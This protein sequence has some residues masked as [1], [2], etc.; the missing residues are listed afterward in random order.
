MLASVHTRLATGL[1]RRAG[2]RVFRFFRRALDP[3][4]TATVPA[5]LE[6]R[7]LSEA[8]VGPLCRRPELDL[9]P[10]KV[11]DA[12]ERGDLCAGAYAAGELVGY[13]WFAFAPVPHLDSVWVDFHQQGVWMYKSLVLPSQ[14]GR[15]VAPA[16]YRFTDRLC[17]ERGRTFSISCIESH[18]R[19]SIAAIRRAGY[20]PSGYGGYLARGRKALTFM[21]PAAKAMAVRF[22]IPG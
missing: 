10:E 12:Y 22:F 4:R 3:A 17:V 1:A 14:R 7:M 8:D 16:L 2:L 6:M 20:A 21:S 15:G 11:A 9:R 19:P 18:N 5:G 13:C